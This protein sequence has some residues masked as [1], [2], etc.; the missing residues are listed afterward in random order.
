MGGGT[1]MVLSTNSLQASKGFCLLDIVS[2]IEVALLPYIIDF[3][4][5]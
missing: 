3:A 2:D 1:F 4:G 5:Q